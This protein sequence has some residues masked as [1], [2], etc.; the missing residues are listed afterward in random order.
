[1]W[2]CLPLPHRL[3]FAAQIAVLL[4]VVAFL[5]GVFLFQMAPPLWAQ[6]AIGA[7]PFVFGAVMGVLPVPDFT[8]CGDR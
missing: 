2:R 8:D 7:S 3:V 5:V 4:A 6:W 1:M